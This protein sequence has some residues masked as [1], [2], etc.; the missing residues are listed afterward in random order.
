MES[1]I[2]LPDV[3]AGIISDKKIAGKRSGLPWVTLAYAQSLDG[4]IA[5]YPGAP[6]AISAPASLEITHQLR[7]RHQAILIGIGTL[8]ADDPRLNVRLVPGENPQPVV[9]DNQLRTPPDSRMLKGAKRPWIMAS[10]RSPPRREKALI[11]AGA[12]VFHPSP[13]KVALADVLEVLR[14][15]GIGSVMVEGGAQVITAF[16][17]ACLVDLIV[18]TISPMLVGGMTALT[19]ALVDDPAL[20]ASADKFPRL[21]DLGVEW[22]QEDLLIWGCPRWGTS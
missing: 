17:Q 12:R 7:A 22:I 13:D 4:S 11:K 6:L 21:D 14:R 9:L 2:E 3:L 18:V 8:L 16:L 5:A 20:P 1:P 10:R 15:E 19:D